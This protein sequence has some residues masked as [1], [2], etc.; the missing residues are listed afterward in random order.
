MATSQTA[1]INAEIEKVRAKIIEWQGKLKELEQKRREAEN[2]EIVEL[3]RGLRIPLDQLAAM[4]SNI[5]TGTSGQ[6]VPKS[7]PKTETED[8]TE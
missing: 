4:L 5:K 8:E 6:T 7:N 2:M 1:K 3:V